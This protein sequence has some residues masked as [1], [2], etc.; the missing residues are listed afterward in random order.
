MSDSLAKTIARLPR[1]EVVAWLDSLD[2]Q[3]A[4][5]LAKEPWWFVARP[6]QMLPPGDWFIWL[7]MTGRRF[8][9]TRA[10]SEN[11]ADLVLANPTGR[12]GAPTEWAVIGETFSDCRKI[13]VEGPSGL[14]RA[15]RSRGLR[16]RHDFNYNR[17]QW[18]ITLTGGQVIHMM[19]AD[20][21]DVGRGFGLEG[22]WADEI[23][24][25]PYA[26]ATWNEGL[27]PALSDST[28]P[29]AI[30]TTTPKTS[31]PLLK[32]WLNRSNGSVVITRGSID[33]NRDNLSPEMLAEMH[34][35]YAGTRMERQELL[36]EFIDSVIG[37]M[38][39]FDMLEL[40]RVHTAPDMSRVVVAIDPAVSN[41]ETSDETGI[42]AVGR[43]VDKRGYTLA[44]RSCR[45]SPM[46]W[47]QRAVNL[48]DE[49]KADLIV[50]E[51]NQGGDM[52]ET[53]LRQI[54]PGI[55]YKGI[56]ATRGK[57]LR[58]QPVSALAEQ[59]RLSMVGYFPE[60]EEQMLNYT[61]EPGEGSPDR[62]DAYVHAV[63][64]LDI[65]V[66]GNADRLISALGV[67][68]DSCNQFSPTGSP[69]CTSCGSRLA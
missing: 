20:S 1:P 32:S 28:H 64:A 29:R 8:G 63:T 52:I 47:A 13:C 21:P 26:S 59:G 4:L 24:K 58:A 39:T 11:L 5:E 54:R 35:L 17:S 62:L 44:D 57:V 36:G 7:L 46:E 56:S 40:Y 66:S 67:K 10:A 27:M 37:A 48:Y 19:G 6:E 43:G 14:L 15:L 22:L 30:V 69:I 55:P 65:G 41:T 31:H 45:L 2:E 60:L 53:I 49:L 18:E 34:D 51:K 12:G 61:G 25:W 9:K 23:A 50:G 33:D 3:V 38:W 68:C 16:D 42:I